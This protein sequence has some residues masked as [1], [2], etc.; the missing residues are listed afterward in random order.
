MLICRCDD[1]LSVLYDSFFCGKECFVIA[2]KSLNLVCDCFYRE[3]LPY[4]IDKIQISQNSDTIQYFIYGKKV[5]NF[6]RHS[7]K[8]ASSLLLKPC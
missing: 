1:E 5:K 6:P 4:N 2:F 3:C 8:L 7:F